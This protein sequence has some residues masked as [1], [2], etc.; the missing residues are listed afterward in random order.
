MQ[1]SH[2]DACPL[3]TGV[4]TCHDTL[5]PTLTQHALGCGQAAPQCSKAKI[6]YFHHT[7]RAIHKDVIT[8]EIPVDDG[9]LM[10]M[11]IHKP[12][13]DLPSPSFEHLLINALVLLA[14]SARQASPR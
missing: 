8:L 14:I 5:P 12:L 7:R 3:L 11:Q 9:G 1:H 6:A 13:Q 10:C 4:H 2:E